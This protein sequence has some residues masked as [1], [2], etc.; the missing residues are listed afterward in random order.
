MCDMDCFHCCKPDCDVDG[1][2]LGEKWEQDKRD[3]EIE[4]D[5]A[6]EKVK[7]RRERQRKYE[8]SEKGKAK[9]KRAQQKRI[10][11]GKNAEACRAYRC[12]QKAKK[13]MEEGVK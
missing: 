13:L 9:A 11:S 5:Q 8:K 7:R 4:L 6:S 3:K 2:T 10:A 1:V 12:R